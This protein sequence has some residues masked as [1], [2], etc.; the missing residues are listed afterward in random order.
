MTAIPSAH[1]NSSAYLHLSPPFLSQYEVEEE[2]LGEGGTESESPA[3]GTAISAMS[4]F[5]LLAGSFHCAVSWFFTVT[6]GR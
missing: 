6:V 4:S 2:A 3:T 1:S 5:C